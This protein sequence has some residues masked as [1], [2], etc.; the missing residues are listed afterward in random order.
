MALSYRKGRATAAV[1]PGEK[2]LIVIAI[3]Y[4]Q[5][6]GRPHQGKSVAELCEDDGA[7]P[8]WFRRGMEA[9]ALAPTAM[10]QQK[11][12]FALC[13]ST[14]RALPGSGFYTKTDLGIAKC[15][16]AV[17]AQGVDWKWA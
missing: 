17:G 15:H 6:Q 5:T 12:R 8:D 10:N 9:V 7:S 2:L 11:F 14:V 16:F 4:G 1:G 3:G 13:G